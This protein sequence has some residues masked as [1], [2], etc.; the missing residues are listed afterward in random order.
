M[1]YF[2][3]VPLFQLADPFDRFILAT[4]AQLRL[5]LVTADRAMSK[6]GLV[7]VIR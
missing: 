2:G 3:R 5:P 4:A 6:T 1:D 7:P